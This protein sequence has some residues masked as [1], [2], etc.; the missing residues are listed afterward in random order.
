MYADDAT[1]FKGI[2]HLGD[3]VTLQNDLNAISLWVEIW[4]LTLNPAKRKH[5]RMG[6]HGEDYTFYLHDCAI[7]QV[8]EHELASNAN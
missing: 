7:E 5:L 4:Q 6:R 3:C 8:K 2:Q 1:L